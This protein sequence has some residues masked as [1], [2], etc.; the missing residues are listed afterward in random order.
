[1]LLILFDNVVL[2]VFPFIREA[3]KATRDTIQLE[4]IQ[5]MDTLEQ[6]ILAT[7]VNRWDKIIEK[8]KA[9]AE[10]NYNNGMDFFVECY[11]RDQWVDEVSRLD[12]TL[13]TWREVKKAMKEHAEDRAEIMEDVRG[14]GD[15][16]A[17]EKL[18]IS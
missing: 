8:A 4:A 7:R 13:K 5:I 10:A 12:G 17:E 16:D 6:A 14:Y 3:G 15:C 18:S 9:Y 2:C 11:E 1:M